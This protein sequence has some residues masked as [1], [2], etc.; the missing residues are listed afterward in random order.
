M[1]CTKYLEPTDIFKLE[2]PEEALEKA[3]TAVRVM[4]SFKKLYHDHRE[5]L[6]DYFRDREP[7]LWEFATPMVFARTDV[8][9]ERLKILVVSIM[10]MITYIIYI[11][12]YISGL[13]VI[14]KLL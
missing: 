10:M 1:Q 6:P 8:Y 3:S 5:K 13:E 14:L 4:E 7:K 11:C 2:D 12:C 9:V